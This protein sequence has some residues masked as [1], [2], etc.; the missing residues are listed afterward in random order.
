MKSYRIFLPLFL[1]FFVAEQKS[2]E[3]ASQTTSK[4]K[5]SKAHNSQKGS[6]KDH[7]KSM[8]AQAIHPA[9]KMLVNNFGKQVGFEPKDFSKV[10]EKEVCSKKAC[11]EDTD[12]STCYRGFRGNIEHPEKGCQGYQ[13][14]TMGQ[15]IGKTKKESRVSSGGFTTGDIT[16]KPG[17]KPG[18]KPTKDALDD[19]SLGINV[20]ENSTAGVT[21]VPDGKTP[22]TPDENPAA[23]IAGI[24]GAAVVG[25]LIMNNIAGDDDNTVTP[26]NNGIHAM[27]APTASSAAAGAGVAGPG[28]IRPTA[29]CSTKLDAE[30]LG[31]DIKQTHEAE[32]ANL[33][34]AAVAG[35]ENPKNS[36]QTLYTLIVSQ[37]AYLSTI[38]DIA[39]L[40]SGID[41]LTGHLNILIG[42]TSI[43]SHF[44]HNLANKIISA[45]SCI[46]NIGQPLP[47]NNCIG[48]MADAMAD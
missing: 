44:S 14:R 5:H 37:L 48:W 23:A 6:K 38:T 46:K 2:V 30:A 4:S 16:S 20:I 42:T 31:A 43:Q 13:R 36:H 26:G 18:G 28:G 32:L 22:T 34:T 27:F 29:A 19:G 9:D 21:P 8:Y 17:R 33:G 35:S 11:M 25:G 39:Q 10:E 41:L 12:Q 1:L 7:S 47:I 3:A 45:V 40:N 15:K 24:G